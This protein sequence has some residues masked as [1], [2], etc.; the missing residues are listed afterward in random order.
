MS[1]KLSKVLSN[2][3]NLTISP[4]TQTDNICSSISSWSVYAAV[5][6]SSIVSSIKS[7]QCY[8]VISIQLKR[9][10][11]HFY[12]FHTHTHRTSFTSTRADLY[13][14][15]PKPL[16]IEK[17]ISDILKYSDMFSNFFKTLTPIILHHFKSIIKKKAE[18][19]LTKH[20][21]GQKLN[22]RTYHKR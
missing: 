18:S 3:E 4:V 12:S 14:T 21:S 15:N 22:Y 13:A 7:T 2:T 6:V 1:N 10:K 17:L 9:Y 19:L 5:I 20:H 8:Q 16:T 11:G